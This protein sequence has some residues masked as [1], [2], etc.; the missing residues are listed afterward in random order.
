MGFGIAA[1]LRY[2]G[3]MFSW[4]LGG[5]KPN[6]AKAYWRQAPKPLAWFGLGS[7]AAPQDPRE[8][9]QSAAQQRGSRGFGSLLR[10]HCALLPNP[11]DLRREVLQVQG[12]IQVSQRVPD[13]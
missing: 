1:P 2:G 9:H 5:A 12:D 10:R 13:R 8:R 3:R 7:L 4:G 11:A 6:T